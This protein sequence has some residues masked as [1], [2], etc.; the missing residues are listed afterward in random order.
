MIMKT[1]TPAISMIIIPMII[2]PMITKKIII[3]I[4]KETATHHTKMNS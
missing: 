4:T 1:T 2:M 3:T